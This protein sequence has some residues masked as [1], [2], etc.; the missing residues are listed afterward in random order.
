MP[1]YYDNKTKTWFAKFRY[2]DWTGKTHYTTRRGFAKKK[3]AQA[4]EAEYKMKAQ[5]NPNLTVDSLVVE[6]LKDYKLYHK[7]S[8]YRAVKRTLENRVLPSFGNLSA[9][10]L[11]PYHIKEWQ[12]E[13]Q[14][15]GAA[16]SSIMTYNTIFSSMLNWGMKYYGLPSNPFTITGKTG[17]NTRRGNM[18]FWELDEFQKFDAALDAAGEVNLRKQEQELVGLALYH[19]IALSQDADKDLTEISHQIVKALLKRGYISKLREVKEYLACMNLVALD[20]SC[21]ESVD[22]CK[23]LIINPKCRIRI[24]LFLQ[25][26]VKML[27]ILLFINLNCGMINGLVVFRLGSLSLAGVLISLALKHIFPDAVKENFRSKGLSDEIYNAEHST[28]LFK[29]FV[30][31][32]HKEY[33]RYSLKTF[34]FFIISQ[35]LNGINTVHLR[36]I[37]L[38]KNKVRLIIFHETKQCLTG[39]HGAHTHIVVAK[40]TSGYR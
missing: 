3:D 11:K 36:H 32:C 15:S 27:K 14:T 22:T 33:N 6:Y 2:H 34:L 26:T 19:D 29:L 30:I 18:D 23:C 24:A 17:Q 16:E 5:H 10:E 1:A 12:N 28:L 20:I 38:D 25:S 8:S 13:L 31:I 7:D 9:A 40:D 35:L 21:K 39:I 37:C 4:F